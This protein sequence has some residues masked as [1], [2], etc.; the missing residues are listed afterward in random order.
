[1]HWT[2]YGAIVIVPLSGWIGHAAATGFAPIWWPLG[3][4]LPLVPKSTGVEHLFGAIHVIAGKVLIGSILLHVAGSLK[5][6]FLDR[7]A[8]LRRMLPGEPA[9]GPLPPQR[10]SRAPVAA[11]V[12]VWAV[13]L[14]VAGV[15]GL[16]DTEARGAEA[17]V[18]AQ[19]ASEW[20]VQDG[21]VGIVVHQFGSDVAGSF[22][23]WTADITFDETVTDGPAG[24]VTAT[25]SIPS[26]TMGSVTQQ[27]LG[28]DFFAASDFPTAVYTG[29]IVR[30]ADGYAVDGTLTIKDLA[31]PMRLP[32]DLTVEG[33]TAQ[34][35]ADATLD[36]RDFAIGAN[37]NDEKT[38]GFDVALRI[39]LTAQ[40]GD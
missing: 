21:T 11:A 26:L 2:L 38:L 16:S 25:I 17:P 6:H 19:V 13:T 4:G 12:A 32:M 30:G 8:T 37:V 35:Q 31:V 5:H 40:R 1:M 29:D 7:D 33:D 36:R 39:A 3:Q 28:A 27:A 22:T 18:L 10:H 20:Q 34:M 24:A 9:I 14:G 15:L 23:D